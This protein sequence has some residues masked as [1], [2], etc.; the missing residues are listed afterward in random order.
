MLQAL[1]SLNLGGVCRRL[2]L[3]RFRPVRPRPRF[4]LRRL[5]QFPASRD[6][7]LIQGNPFEFSVGSYK[8]RK[9]YGVKKIK[10]DS[11]PVLKALREWLKVSPNPDFVLVNVKTGSPMSSLQITQ[12]LTRIF[13]LH[14]NTVR[15]ILS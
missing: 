12:N 10:I 8:T 7:P 15:Q 4:R 9:K 2:V 14:F 13:K 5:E 11:K 1:L 3:H 6:V